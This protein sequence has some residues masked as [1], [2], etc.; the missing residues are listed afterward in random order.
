MAML[1]FE[2]RRDGGISLGRSKLGR[3]SRPWE[4]SVSKG[5]Q[6]G[7]CERLIAFALQLSITTDALPDPQLFTFHASAKKQASRGALASVRV[8]CWR[9]DGSQNHCVE[10]CAPECP[11]SSS[12]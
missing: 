2:H 7:W 4:L 6:H 3:A 1:S 9:Q 10:L 11:S 5:A 12:L 8:M